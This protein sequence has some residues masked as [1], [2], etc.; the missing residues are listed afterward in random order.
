MD[1]PNKPPK[2]GVDDILQE[3]R[4]KG[5]AGPGAKPG[6]VDDVLAELGL[7]SR[8]SPLASRP[9]PG[10]APKAAPA[11]APAAPA[12]PAAPT[13]PAAPAA[14]A[15]PTAPA[16]AAQAVLFAG[17]EDAGDLFA[18]PAQN[19]APAAAE[20]APFYRPE[21]A[22]PPRPVRVRGG[23]FSQGG[24]SIWDIEP[25]ETDT[26]PRVGKAAALQWVDPEKF[27]G[28][29]ELLSWFS[30]DEGD[31][32][33]A[34]KERK[35]QEKLEKQRLAEEAREEKRQTKRRYA[36]DDAG[37][38]I[39]DTP[40]NDAWPPLEAPM[41]APL[42]E[43]GFAAPALDD[44]FG[45]ESTPGDALFTDDFA[46]DSAFETPDAFSAPA[47]VNT[48]SFG[49]VQIEAELLEGVLP[50]TSDTAAFDTR[51]FDLPGPE[52]PGRVPTA[53]YTQ[54]FDTAEDDTPKPEA[55]KSLFVDEMVDDRF[56]DFFKETVIM[57]REEVA[58][59]VRGGRRRRR[60]SRSALLTGEFGRLA[61]LATD[62][63]LAAQRALEDPESAQS[64]ETFEDYDRPQD[65][66]AIEGDLAALRSTLTR[67]TLVTGVL[68]VL[69]LWMG[70]AFS[71]FP[72]PEFLQ[73][74]V[75]PMAFAIVWLVLLGGVIA[76]NIT[77]VSSGVVGLFGEPTSDTAPA[78]ASVAA[79]MQG[80]ALLV[81]ALTEEVPAATLFGALAGFI[82]CFNALGKRVRAGS[83]MRNFQL[84]SAGYDHSAAY[85]LDNQTELAY[86]ITTGLEEENPCLLVSRPTAL[87][88]GFLRQSFSPRASDQ[89]GRV[90]G[91]VLLACAAAG[92]VITLLL[93][94]LP[95]LFSGVTA[96]TAI[97]CIG[98]PL[99]ST[100]IAGIPS[101]LLQR[102]ASRVGAV[103]P[104]W[105]AIE[106]LG[107]V[108]VVM[109]TARDVFPPSSVN[110][111]GI[112][113]FEKERVDLAILYAA[114]VL[115]E[116]CDTLRDIF[117]AV[118]QGKSEM[119]YKVESLT[120]EPGRGFTAWVENSRV[121]IGSREML[122]RH[123][124]AP[125][126][127][128][129]ELK[130]VPA[131][132]MPVYLA[133]SGKLFAMFI[134]RYGAEPEVQ[135]TLDSLVRSGVSLLVRSDDMN[136]T[137]ELIETAYNLPHGTVKVLGKRELD[138]LEPLTAYLPES[139][140]V[141]TH[142]GTFS[143]FIGGMRAA[144]TCALAERMAAIVQIVS[145][146]LI[147]ALCLLLA[148]SGGLLG[149]GVWVGLL[150]QLAWGVVA[151]ALPFARRY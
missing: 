19:P 147:A 82:L 107:R 79:L 132:H 100:L 7:G 16:Q 44:T 30:E 47:G 54:E 6:A 68:S 76:F 36:E 140:G 112:K 52:D 93:T 129:L 134:V 118:I 65:A 14:P 124:I 119:L 126:P 123:D 35:R 2:A 142:I 105:S 12:A 15:A 45:G 3:L 49:A 51:S 92:V 115:V 150:Y 58:E 96:F 59:G 84:A 88:K 57:D 108:N 78:L 113:T 39:Q 101:L 55:P 103:V 1:T 63:E 87:V 18:R 46:T 71:G 23:K 73:Y 31:S 136:V 69:L 83:I 98:A 109:A 137:E 27:S 29:T 139:E 22:E 24:G 5:A 145:V 80:V 130:H 42:P 99:S 95:S 86:N 9:M 32:R 13:A 77:T 94:P 33:A 148:F 122:Q 66:E 127:V 117:L 128:E 151:S 34:K 72:I 74:S 143:S 28:E 90:I 37:D 48:L 121:V 131:G 138:V 75:H 135:D 8:K 106:D 61:E 116:G 85:V 21:A 17:E 104:G 50:E 146:G 144:A 91:W 26:P 38:G 11:P 43:T 97:L 20:P 4:A 62:A 89:S 141:M 56:R 111:K 64:A 10:A 125:P 70:L 25:Q 40:D 120:K 60:K 53:A 114:S 149:L 67:R 102:G 81:A 133:V 110:L 41:D